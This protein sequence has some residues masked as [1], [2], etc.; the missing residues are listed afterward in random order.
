MNFKR[1]LVAVDS[2]PQ[3]SVVFEQ[4]LGL[5]KKDSAT[6]MIFNGLELAAKRTY[7]TELEEKTEEA[8]TLLENYQQKANTQGV[9]AEVNYQ[10]GEAGK[11]ICNLAENWNADLIV[12]GRRGYKGLTAVLLG[13]VSNYVVY[14]SH[15]SVLVLQGEDYK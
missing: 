12:V 6:L 7:I 1:I 8:K 2:S 11:S 15:C 4:A 13:S 14:H 3:A 5:A 10:P 9:S